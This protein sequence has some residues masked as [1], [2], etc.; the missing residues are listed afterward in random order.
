MANTKV[1]SEQIE[2]GSITA[3]KLADGT[4]VAAELADNA[5]V[6]A[7]INADAVTGAKI[8]DNAIDS[9]H[10]TDGSIDTA[11]I[12]DAQITVA[13]MAANS[14]D[15]DQYVD[16]SI[17]TVHLGDLQVTTAKIANGNISTAK[18]ADNAVTSAKIDTN[19]D[20]AGTFDVTGATTLDSTL[21]VAGATTLTTAAAAAEML[22]IVSTHASGIPILTLKGAHSA[23]VR[24]QDENGNNQA[25]I[26]F[27]DAGQF[28]FLDATDGTSHLFIKNDGNVGIGTTSPATLLHVF[29]GNGSYPDDANTH[30]VVESDS[31]AYIGIGGGTSSDVG[32]HFGDSGGVN[33]GRIAY[34]NSDDALVFNTATAETMRIDSSGNVGIGTTSPD[35]SGFSKALTIDSS[36]S[37]IELASSGTIQAMFASNTQGATIHGVGSSGIRVFTSASGSTSE[38]MRIDSSG[39][40][41]IGCVPAHELDVV[42]T[43]RMQQSGSDLFSTIRG[44]LNRDLRIDINANNDGD[45]LKVRDLRDN[46]VRFVVEAGGNVGIGTA[47]P[48]APLHVNR[49]GVGEAIRFTDSTT[50]TGHLNVVSG[51]GC[52][53]WAGGFLAFGAGGGGSYTER[54][55]I[56]TSG[57]LQVGFS[58]YASLGTVNTGCRLSNDGES[59]TLARGSN[60]TIL[61]F[62]SGSGGAGYISVSGNAASYNTSSDYRLKEN[63]TPIENGLDR[64]NSLNPV[65]FDW[66]DDGTSS[67][68]FIAHEAQEVFPDAVSGE[69]DGE[70][71][72]GI[73]YG[74]ITPLLV[75]AIQEQQEQIEQ[76]KTE[77]EA[78][79]S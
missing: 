10:Y 45:G 58:S 6:T 23:Q 34:K 42:G 69:K 62:Y 1:Q 40:V 37:G 22:N 53:L 44:P 71:M 31:H 32:I 73:D 79:K 46:S 26:D 61:A 51:G 35:I 48:S 4:I 55:R 2:D 19:I 30:F 78:L 38:R 25:R 54:M 47:S 43:L 65:K 76:L 9:E 63:I 14:V 27:N 49:S 24:Y 56:D 12:A 28:N 50:D 3:D 70:D 21:A 20:I 16:G 36:E 60:G 11:H 39:N 29:E 52:S 74:R 15:S 13:K 72:Q 41:G 66:K 7:A 8:A 67:E 33:R 57:N 64:L 18:I 75:K 59:N 77:I 68:G 5:V 17:D